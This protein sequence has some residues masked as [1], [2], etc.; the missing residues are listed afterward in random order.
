MRWRPEPADDLAE[1]LD[2][3][4]DDVAAQ[5]LLAEIIADGRG[6]E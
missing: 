4:D 1:L 2:D 5:V 6:D 3:A